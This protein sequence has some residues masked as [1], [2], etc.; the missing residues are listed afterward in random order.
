MNPG[1]ADL[2][3]ALRLLASGQEIDS[4]WREAGYA[5]RKA[6]ADRIWQVAD[7]IASSQAG[8]EGEHAL[9][10]RHKE[11]LRPGVVGATSAAGPGGERRAAGRKP[12]AKAK[13]RTWLRVTAYSDGG[14]I[15]NPG[16][17]G[18]GAVLI[19]ESGEVLLEDHKYL[20]QTTN[21][22]AEYEGAVLA[23]TRARELGAREVELKVDSEL[24]VNQIKGGYRVKSANLAG[25]YNQLKELSR[26]FDRFEISRIGRGENK[27]ADKLA[28]LAMASR[29]RE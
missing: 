23:L 26:Q 17:A 29:A 19:D 18:C 27:R 13:G 5:S 21:N 2:A 4:V 9:F 15:G 11:S 3:Y 12:V 25:L 24:L 6:L 1:R 8:A 10:A 28:N 14:S 20:G 16:H 7:Q 22:V